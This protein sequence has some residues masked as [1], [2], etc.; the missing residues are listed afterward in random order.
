MKFDRFV[1]LSGS[2]NG[3]GWM[4]NLAILSPVNENEEM[5][6]HGDS[7]LF[8]TTVLRIRSRGVSLMMLECSI[9]NRRQLTSPNDETSVILGSHEHRPEGPRTE[10]GLAFPGSTR[11]ES[12]S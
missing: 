5:P 10:S 3:I 9:L 1:E 2:V 4:R 11:G 6:T 8:G 12:N 7:R